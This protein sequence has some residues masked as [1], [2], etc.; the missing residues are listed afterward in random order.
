MNFEERIAAYLDGELG[1]REAEE[2]EAAFIDPKVSELLSEELLVRELLAAL[3]PEEAPEA[4]VAR[5]EGSLG[6][7]AGLGA[8]ARQRLR[9][10]VPGR[11]SAPR[12]SW[13]LQGLSLSARALT[14]APAGVSNVRAAA[15]G[16]SSLRRSYALV[17][18][19]RGRSPDGRSAPLWQRAAA[20]LWRRRK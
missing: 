8:R 20:M 10:L 14:A 16:A 5:I 7:S 15:S 17:S 9:G 4:L 1:E 6:V 12:R 2:L 11:S 19:L 18:E 13:A 3:P